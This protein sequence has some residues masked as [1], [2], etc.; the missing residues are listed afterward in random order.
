MRRIL[1]ILALMAHLLAAMA[2]PA[3]A[4]AS[5]NPNSGCVGKVAKSYNE[6]QP[7]LRGL[8]ISFVAQVGTVTDTAHNRQCV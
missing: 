5:N 6:Q 8:Q 2:P 7:G 4:F 3:F 1:A